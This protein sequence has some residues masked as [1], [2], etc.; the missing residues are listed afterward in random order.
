MLFSTNT[1]SSVLISETSGNLRAYVKRE[2]KASATETA[3]YCTN[4]PEIEILLNNRAQLSFA[5]I[6]PTRSKLG[7][8][9]RM[10]ASVW[11]VGLGLT[12]D[13]T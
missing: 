6:A 4:R 8:F 2:N 13:G 1:S 7:R 10:L 3:G 11:F 5:W 9:A 12:C